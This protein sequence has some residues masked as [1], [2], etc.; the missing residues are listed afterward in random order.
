MKPM[1]RVGVD[2]CQRRAVVALGASLVACAIA[3]GT[4]SHAQATMAS[5]TSG[6]ARFSRTSDTIQV[7][8]N[9][10]FNQGNFTYE[11]H[12]RFDA[13]GQS[14]PIDPNSPRGGVISEQFTGSE[15]KTLQFSPDGHYVVS[16]SWND[17]AVGNNSGSISGFPAGD[18]IH[19]AYVRAGNVSTIYINGTAV[20]AH[21]TNFAYV[22]APGSWMS[23][24]MFR[25]GAGYIATPARPSFI[26]DLDWI[27]V[28]SG[29]LY[30]ANF[31]PPTE[32]AVAATASTQ[33]L[34]KFNE[35]AGTST[36]YD[37][38]SNA[39]QGNLGV[40]VYPGVTATAPTL[41]TGT[42]PGPGALVTMA[43]GVMTSRRRRR[44]S[45]RLADD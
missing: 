12:I 7:L 42:V 1:N 27:R 25:Q 8:G 4:A 38:S 35:A 30:T 45:S 20:A 22:D 16:A 26:G 28:S 18:W 33:L 23:I 3:M 43:L 6:F 14:G 32:S 41:M 24:G 31:V 5:Y 36:I 17:P 9:T 15:D 29:A 19:L 10:V 44:G 2:R 11:M 21:V 13:A 34:Y 40:A 39:F 37:E